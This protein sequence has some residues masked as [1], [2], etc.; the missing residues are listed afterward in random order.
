MTPQHVISQ[1][2]ESDTKYP[3]NLD[4]LKK[5]IL[6]AFYGRLRINGSP[7]EKQVPLGSYLFDEERIIF[8]F[9]GLSE[10]GKSLYEKWL[11]EPHQNDKHKGLFSSVSVNEF[12]GFTAEVSLGLWG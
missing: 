4:L 11:L 7:P 9:T 2:L 3:Q 6:T 12:R 1:L 10:A 5:I 8:D